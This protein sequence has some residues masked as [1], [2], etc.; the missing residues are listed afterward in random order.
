MQN[1]YYRKVSAMVLTLMI[2]AA[3]A[4]AVNTAPTV[5]EDDT[6]T[7]IISSSEDNAENGNTFEE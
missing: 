1:R 3:T 4:T 6:S 7:S 5:S 2:T